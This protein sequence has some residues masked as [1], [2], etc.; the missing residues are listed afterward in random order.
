[1]ASVTQTVAEE[2]TT[3]TL[4]GSSAIVAEFFEYAVNSILYQRGILPPEAFKRAAKYG[5]TIMKVSDEGLVAYFANVMR[6]LEDWLLSGDVQQ[7][8]CVI[9][10]F[11]SGDALERWVFKVE[12][13]DTDKENAGGGGAAAEKQPEKSVKEVQSEI[14]AIIRQITASV[15]F[16]PMIDEP[17]SFD[18]LV[19]TNA[20]ATVPLKWEE[21]DARYIPGAEEVKLR[22]FST[23]VHVV[24]TTVAYRPASLD[25]A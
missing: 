13:T 3:I 11:E 22:S 8:V 4:R 18:L 5:L 2:G 21:T 1:M 20:S 7:L 24:G 19:Y 14:A 12:T 16:L 9:N 23:K 15:T 25:D 10:G 17:C 6:Q